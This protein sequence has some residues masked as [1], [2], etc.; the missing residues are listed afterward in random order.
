MKGKS[1]SQKRSLK[2][3]SRTKE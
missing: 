2:K 3:E 1:Q